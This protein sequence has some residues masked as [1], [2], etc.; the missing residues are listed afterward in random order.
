MKFGEA[1][2]S[3]LNQYATFRGRARRSEYW[4]F[5]LFNVIV[6]SILSWLAQRIGFFWTI[7]ALYALAVFLPGLA[8]T[9]RRLHDTGKSGG[10]I[11]ICLVPV[12]GT[13]ILLVNLARPGQPGPNAYGP[14]PKG[15]AGEAGEKAPWEY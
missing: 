5:F 12:V 13:I 10:W 8:V 7:D 14:D 6:S 1:I 9:C 11:F 15:W 3:V 4:Y 2:A